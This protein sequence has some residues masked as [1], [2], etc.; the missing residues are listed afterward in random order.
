MIARNF[1]AA[2]AAED[3]GVYCVGGAYQIIS[4]QALTYDES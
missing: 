3:A 2:N 4:R 1:S